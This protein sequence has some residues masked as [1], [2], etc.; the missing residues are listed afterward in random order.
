MPALILFAAIAAV[1][2]ALSYATL[3]WGVD[4][5]EFAP[6]RFVATALGVR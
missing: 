2:A 5:R 1:F 6:D 3:R 4:S